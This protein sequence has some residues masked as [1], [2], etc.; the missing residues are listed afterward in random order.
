[1]G[2]GFLFYGFVFPN[3]WTKQKATEKKTNKE[4]NFGRSAMGTSFF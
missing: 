2:S 3:T 4:S 1:M